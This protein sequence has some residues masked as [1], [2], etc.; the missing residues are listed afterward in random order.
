MVDIHTLHT[1]LH[2]GGKRNEHST[3]IYKIYN[4]TLTVS[5][6]VA[7]LSAVQDDCVQFLQRIWSNWLCTA[8]TE[9]HPMF[10]F[11]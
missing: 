2:C 8:F 3:N 10:V 11:I 7:M 4:F 5:S 9:S 1:C 6:I